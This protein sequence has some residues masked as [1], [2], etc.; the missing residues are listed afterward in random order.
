MLILFTLAFGPYYLS[1][2]PVFPL[3]VRSLGSHGADFSL[4]I[5]GDCSLPTWIP[6]PNSVQHEI[7]SWY[8]MTKRLEIF[9]G[10]NV[11]SSRNSTIYTKACDFKPISPA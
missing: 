11:E 3:L 7:I 4:I 2:H 5:L 6:T 1:S 8:E 10:K 9:L